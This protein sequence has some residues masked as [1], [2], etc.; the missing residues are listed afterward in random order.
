MAPAPAVPVDLDE[1][2]AEFQGQMNLM[3][4]RARTLWKESA[5]RVHPELHPLGYKLLS[6]VARAGSTTA[7]QL[8]ESFEV[9]K[10][11]VSRQV[12]MLEDLGL[13]R[14]Q[15]DERDGRLRTLSASPGACTALAEI[16][17]DHAER[18]RVA[19]VEL[20]PEELLVAAKV[21]RVFAEF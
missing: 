19:L 2:V 13:L 20:A 4:A 14:S 6:F 5:A 7:H 10:S 18:M 16:R 21:L 11:V 15:P 3:F 9:D 8:A 1:S 12:R 17:A